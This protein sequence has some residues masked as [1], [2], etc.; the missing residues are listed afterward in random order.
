[1]ASD[2]LLPFSQELGIDHYTNPCNLSIK[3]GESG[4]ELNTYSNIILLSM[5][6]NEV[7]S[8]NKCTTEGTICSQMQMCFNHEMQMLQFVLRV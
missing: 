3:L 1:M 4:L 8:G 6:V 5:T 7:K 2:S